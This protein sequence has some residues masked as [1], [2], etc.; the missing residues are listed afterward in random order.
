MS[1]LP[2]VKIIVPVDPLNEKEDTVPV[3][4]NGYNYL[5]KR[6]V[7]VDVPEPIAKILEE[8]GYLGGTR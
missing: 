4:I 7:A 2:K 3:G 1:K 8:S 6:G 5:I